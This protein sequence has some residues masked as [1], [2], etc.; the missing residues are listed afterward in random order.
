MEGM[1]MILFFAKL[2][3]GTFALG[4]FA[5]AFGLAFKGIDRK[6][7]AHMQSRV[8]P[9]LRQ[10]FRDVSKLMY[11]QTI[12]PENAIDW[13]Y[14][15]AP[16]IALASS[17]MVLLYLPLL[18]G[19]EPLLEG[20]G[21]L[22]LVAYLFIIPSLAMVVG[23]FASGSPFASVGAQREMVQMMSYEFPLATVIVALA[24]KV[25]SLDVGVRAFS[26]QS[27]IDYPIWD[28]VGLL[29]GLGA[30]L[31][32]IALLVVTPAELAKVPFDAPEAETEICGGLMAEYSGRN[33]ALF[34]L[35]DAVKT[36]AFG[37]I[38]IALFFP[39]NLSPTINFLF[40]MDMN[41]WAA[42][43][44]DF[45]FYL[46]KLLVI[47]V[48]AVTFP[49]TGFSRLKIDQISRVYWKN[50]TILALVGLLLIVLDTYI[51]L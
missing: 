48:A 15:A 11:K 5:I 42:G 46:L 7:H 37:T 13:V 3:L 36:I 9:P 41:V 35:S 32:L 12:V 4:L 25:N 51:V 17:I 27:L 38:T 30:L 24:W 16:I 26:F 8:G 28:H 43:I 21:D 19:Y 34:Y 40:N 45:L 18:G 23:G 2:I 31:L 20:H 1:E 22:I 44:I 14:N 50:M 33:Y 6:I 49:R 29:G 10:P 47:V 39:Y